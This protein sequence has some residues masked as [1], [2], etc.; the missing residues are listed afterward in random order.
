MQQD[1]TNTEENSRQLNYSN[2]RETEHMNA[3]SVVNE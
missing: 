1:M 3:E 2:S